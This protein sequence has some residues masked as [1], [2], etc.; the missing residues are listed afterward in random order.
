MKIRTDFVTNSS[1]SSF[2]I[3][4][5]KRPKNIQEFIQLL[6]GDHDANSLDMGLIQTLYNDLPSEGLSDDEIENIFQGKE[7]VTMFEDYDVWSK[8]SYQEIADYDH[9][10]GAEKAK[11]F[12]D[13][14]HNGS[15]AFVFEVE[16]EDHGSNYEGRLYDSDFLHL[17]PH[18]T[19][20]NH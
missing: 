14:I 10:I 4:L 5:K 9:K 11:E 18:Q 2:I 13:D 3:A 7:W 1:S 8:M 6:Y 12:I 16:Y 17:L 20:N 19:F 15:A